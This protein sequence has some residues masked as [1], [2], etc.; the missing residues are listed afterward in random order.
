M[1]YLPF[2]EACRVRDASHKSWPFILTAVL[3]IKVRGLHFLGGLSLASVCKLLLVLALC[4]VWG[5]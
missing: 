5:H 3:C 1:K 2:A 4:M